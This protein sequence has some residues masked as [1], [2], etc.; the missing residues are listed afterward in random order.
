M[1][2]QRIFTMTRAGLFTVFDLQTFDVMYSRDFSKVSQ[3]I[4]AFA[5]SHKV[6]LVFESEI[7]VL[8]ANSKTNGY[9]ELKDYEIK[10]NKISDAKLN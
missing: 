1:Q 9:I 2:S 8:D 3:N 10:L 4:I 7:M 5:H 6:L